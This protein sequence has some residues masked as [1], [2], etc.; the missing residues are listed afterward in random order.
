M[1]TDAAKREEA[2]ARKAEA[3]AEEA[4]RRADEMTAKMAEQT[5]RLQEENAKLIAAL[6][7]GGPA[8]IPGQQ[9]YRDQVQLQSDRRKWLN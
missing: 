7:G 1:A 9:W 6:A 5:A 3:L 2:A 4:A 8:A